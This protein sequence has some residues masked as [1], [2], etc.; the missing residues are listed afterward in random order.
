MPRITAV[1]LCV[2]EKYSYF[3]LLNADLVHADNVELAPFHERIFK[4]RGTIKHKL[5]YRIDGTEY[6]L[7]IDAETGEIAWNS[8]DLVLTTVKSVLNVWLMVDAVQKE[9]FMKIHRD[10]LVTA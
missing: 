9:E 7:I 3:D 6:E 4:F 10:F 8:D 1:M 2:E 5:E